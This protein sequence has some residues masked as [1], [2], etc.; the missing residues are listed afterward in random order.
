MKGTRLDVQRRIAEEEIRP[1]RDVGRAID[2][3]LEAL[4]MRALAQ[5]PELRY[6]SAGEFA[7]DLENY[8]S[9]EPLLARRPTTLYFLRKRMWKYRYWL[10]GAALLLLAAIG[11][12]FFYIHSLTQEQARTHRARVLAEEQ[13]QLAA[14]Q[15]DLALGTLNM[16]V[17]E[18]QRQLSEGLGQI[19]LRKDLIEI[20]MK[21]LRRLADAAEGRAPAMDRSTAAALLQVGDIFMLAGNAKEARSAYHQALERFRDLARAGPDDP[22]AQRDLSVALTRMGRANLQTADLQASDENFR[23][24]L[25]LVERLREARPADRTLLR[26]HWALCISL[27]DVNLEAGE[28]Q[29]ACAH[30]TKALSVARSL[31][32]GMPQQAATQRDL[33]ISRKRLGDGLLRRGDLPGALEQYGEAL[34]IDRALVSAEPNSPAAKRGLSVSLGKMAEAALKAGQRAEA[35]E[36]GEAAVAIIEALVLADPDRFEAK[37]DL[38]AA[39]FM[40]GETERQDGRKERAAKYYQRAVS[41]LQE[42]QEAGVLEGLPKYRELLT[43]AQER[44]RLMHPATRPGG[45]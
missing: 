44:L 34:K 22:G 42:L 13:R 24:A 12:I 19:Q 37:G 43:R 2:R 10:A 41:I 21:G 14:E 23:A 33:A 38:S 18:V 15:R 17:F 40:L 27:G 31:A 35:R 45:A 39:L 26:D 29:I 36:H 7:K 16:L 6:A 8:L 9:G 3:E 1:P 32:E 11:G 28:L 20:A 25:S 30:F 5:D 4:L